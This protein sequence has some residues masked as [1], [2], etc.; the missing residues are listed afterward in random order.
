VGIER[1][2]SAYERRAIPCT[3]SV[4]KAAVDHYLTGRHHQGIAG[5]LIRPPVLTGNDNGTAGAIECLSRLSGLLNTT[6][7][8]RRDVLRWVCGHNDYGIGTESR[9]TLVNYVTC[10]CSL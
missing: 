2:R 8:R 4:Q 6:I 5:Q 10:I 7:A 3:R 9:T 1:E